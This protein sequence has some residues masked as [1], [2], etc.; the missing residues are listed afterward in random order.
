MKRL[1]VYLNQEEADGLRRLAAATGKSMVLPT[2]QYRRQ[3]VDQVNL[4][5]AR[6]REDTAAWQTEIAERHLLDGTLLDGLDPNE[7][8]TEKGD[9]AIATLP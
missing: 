4:D 1:S 8:W 6:L 7:I 5:Y 2:D 9:A 3:F